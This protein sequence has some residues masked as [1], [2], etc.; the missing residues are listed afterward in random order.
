MD[1]TVEQQQHKPVC[2]R[3]GLLAD[4]KPTNTATLWHRRLGHRHLTDVRMMKDTNVVT[5][6]RLLEK[7][8]KIPGVCDSCIL[9]KMHRSPIPRV[10]KRVEPKVK[11]QEVTIDIGVMNVPTTQKFRYFLIIIEHLTRRGFG[12]LLRLK[13]DAV[14]A[15][16]KFVNLIKSS[17]DAQPLGVV[18]SDNE[19]RTEACV[20]CARVRVFYKFGQL[21]ILLSKMLLRSGAF[22]PPRR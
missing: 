20:F 5:G 9:A 8:L 13:S 1:P 3:T 11:L 19:F 21:Q 7:D 4:A 10:S 22:E 12:Y 14:A 17:S 18:Y 16:T 2:D 6:V 15:F